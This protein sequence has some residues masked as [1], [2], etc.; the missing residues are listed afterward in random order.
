MKD[1]F[2]AIQQAARQFQQYDDII[3]KH[4]SDI[5]TI[6]AE[7]LYKLWLFFSDPKN[8]TYNTYGWVYY[9]QHI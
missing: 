5:L 9:L 2:N 6:T 8:N 1:D 4:I 3:Q 7:S